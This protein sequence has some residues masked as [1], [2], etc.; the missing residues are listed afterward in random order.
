M[1]RG[2]FCYAAISRRPTQVR[3]MDDN[4][5]VGNYTYQPACLTARKFCVNGVEAVDYSPRPYTSQFRVR[6]S[7]GMPRFPVTQYSE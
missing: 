4:V 6:A 2:C 5:S 7:F 1:V 3:Y